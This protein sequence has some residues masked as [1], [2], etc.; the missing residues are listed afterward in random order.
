MASLTNI[1]C[2]SVSYFL[3]MHVPAILTSDITFNA[4]AVQEAFAKI[5]IC[6][7]ST[8]PHLSLALPEP[9]ERPSTADVSMWISSLVLVGVHKPGLAVVSVETAVRAAWRCEFDGGTLLRPCS[10][11]SSTLPTNRDASSS[12]HDGCALNICVRTRPCAASE[13][14]LANHSCMHSALLACLNSTNG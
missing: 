4:A 1:A 13:R 5:S 14:C 9:P 3:D 11:R 8:S 6:N 10:Q 7:T 12:G 2:S